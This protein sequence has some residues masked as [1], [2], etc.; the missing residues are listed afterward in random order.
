MRQ[1]SLEEENEK[2]FIMTKSIIMAKGINIP[3]FYIVAYLW[4]RYVQGACQFKMFTEYC[5]SVLRKDYPKDQW[6]AYHY[7]LDSGAL[8][9]TL[10]KKDTP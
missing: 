4:A 6:E 2:E 8:I 5:Y 7:Q 1:S 10:T 3:L 9:F